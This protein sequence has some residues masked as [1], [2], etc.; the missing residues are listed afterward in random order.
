MRLKINLKMAEETVMFDQ[1]AVIAQRV[2][3]RSAFR[4]DLVIYGVGPAGEDCDLGNGG[5]EL[6]ARTDP[7][8]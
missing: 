5:R 6:V 8:V 2:A 1:E 3:E 7:G 4:T